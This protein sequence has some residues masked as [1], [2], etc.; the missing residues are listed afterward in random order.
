MAA[1]F[2][3]MSRGCRGDETARQSPWGL[4]GGMAPPCPRLC[5]ARLDGG[6]DCSSASSSCRAFRYAAVRIAAIPSPNSAPR[7]G[8]RRLGRPDAMSNS[9]TSDCRSKPVA[10]RRRSRSST[11]PCVNAAVSCGNDVVAPTI[12]R[13]VAESK[14]TG[15]GVASALVRRGA[16]EAPLIGAGACLPHLP[17]RQRRRVP[18]EPADRTDLARGPPK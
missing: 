3:G 18:A 5:C 6:R 16:R 15:G 1:R 7:K 2:R 10:S 4:P 14:G 12:N 9:R 11:R 8:T 17:R 13:G